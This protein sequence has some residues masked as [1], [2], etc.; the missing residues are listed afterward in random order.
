MNY[1]KLGQAISRAKVSRCG[2]NDYPVLSITMKDGIVMQ[3]DKF[4][5]RIASKDISEYKVIPAGMLV[6]GIHMDEGNFGIQDI[7]PHGIVSPAYTVWTVDESVVFPKYIEMVLRSPRCIDYY[8]SKLNGTVN[9]RGHMSEGDFL[10]MQIPCPSIEEQKHVVTTMNQVKQ[11]MISLTE[12]MTALDQ[13]IKARFVEMFGDPEYNNK[14]WPLK[15]LNDLCNIGSSKRIYQ[16]EQTMDGVPFWRISDLV[17]KMD[18]GN[19]ESSLFIPESRYEELKEQ[20]LVPESGDILVTSRGTL[21]RCYIVDPDDRFYFQDGMIS[22]L[23]KYSDEITPLYIQYLFDMSG[24]RKQIDGLQA[25]STVAYLSIAML[26]KLNVMV[27]SRKL[28]EQ[29]AVFVSQVDKSKVVVQEALEKAQLL[30][31]SLMQQYFG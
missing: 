25:G 9:R 19:V 15:K 30:F 13:L 28:Q 10:G 4:K 11:V 29:F 27:P 2:D 20:G 7:V 26:K 21:G 14:G 17:S 31:D 6:Q 16:E 23:S 8:R 18:T 3:S 1:I 12:E 22:W 24:F 5:K